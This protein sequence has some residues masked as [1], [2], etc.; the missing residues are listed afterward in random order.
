MELFNHNFV[1]ITKGYFELR[2]EKII[3]TYDC[4]TF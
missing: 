1:A 3:Q 2:Q 4:L